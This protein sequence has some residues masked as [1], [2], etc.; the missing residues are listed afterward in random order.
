VVFLVT[1]GPSTG[2]TGT[3]STG[4]DG[5]ASFTYFGAI[6]GRDTVEATV[7]SVSATPVEVRW[8]GPPPHL[9]RR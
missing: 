4:L 9:R 8:L 3:V 6:R 2:T 7:G 5:S 1:S